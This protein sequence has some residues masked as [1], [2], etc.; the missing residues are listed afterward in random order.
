MWQNSMDE[1]WTDRSSRTEKEAR[2]RQQEKTMN[3]TK[4]R[5]V[6][7]YMDLKKKKKKKVDVEFKDSSTKEGDRQSICIYHSEKF[8]KNV[9]SSTKSKVLVELGWFWVGGWGLLKEQEKRR[10][11]RDVPKGT[12]KRSTSICWL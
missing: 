11:N 9:N 4:R 6:Y 5:S 12:S 2:E 10:R 8:F 3:R 1:E 7:V